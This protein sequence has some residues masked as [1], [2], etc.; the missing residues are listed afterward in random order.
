MN[1]RNLHIFAHAHLGNSCID[2]LYYTKGFIQSDNLTRGSGRGGR[3]PERRLCRALKRV[4]L[5]LFPFSL[6]AALGHVVGP[7]R[8]PAYG[9]VRSIETATE[10]AGRA[11]QSACVGMSTVTTAQE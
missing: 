8:M 1:L 6:F 9:P 11:R 4:A 2:Y 10:I 3:A 5:W 7:D